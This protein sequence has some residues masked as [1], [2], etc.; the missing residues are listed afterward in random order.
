MIR[1]SSQEAVSKSKYLTKEEC[2]ERVKEYKRKM[3]LN[4]SLEEIFNYHLEE[5]L[6]FNPNKRVI[7]FDLINIGKE[8][9]IKEALNSDNDI[10][11]TSNGLLGDLDKYYKLYLIREKIEQSPIYKNI[12]F[13]ENFEDDGITFKSSLYIRKNG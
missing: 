3:K 4:L 2:L 7:T 11:I 13:E 10:V 6:N 1:M 5:V 12:S 9:N 8:K